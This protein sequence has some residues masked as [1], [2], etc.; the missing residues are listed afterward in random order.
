MPHAAAR[1]AYLQR[2]PSRGAEVLLHANNN[3]SWDVQVTATDV[4]NMP[5]PLGDDFLLSACAC[6]CASDRIPGVSSGR[7]PGIPSVSEGDWLRKSYFATLW[8]WRLNFR[9]IL[10]PTTDLES[11]NECGIFSASTPI[12]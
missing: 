11:G 7:R 3:G 1:A 12:P 10:A 6:A 5:S 4:G 8:R 2:F 9:L